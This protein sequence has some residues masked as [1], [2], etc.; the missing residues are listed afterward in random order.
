MWK[1][2]VQ[3]FWFSR[4]SM[5][6]KYIPESLAGCLDTWRKQVSIPA[7]TSVWR[8]AAEE[9]GPSCLFVWVLRESLSRAKLNRH[10]LFRFNCRFKTCQPST[11]ILFCL[12]RPDCIEPSC[13]IN[14][15]VYLSGGWYSTKN[16]TADKK[17]IT[18]C[19]LW[20]SAPSADTDAVWSIPTGCRMATDQRLTNSDILR[21]DAKLHVSSSQNDFYH[22]VKRIPHDCD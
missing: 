15:N 21:F 3:F 19:K 2:V 5:K 16:T 17:I 8:T 4:D 22:F 11:N 10:E 14:G 1:T 13:V 20:W 7:W 6:K 18:E 9:M 12:I